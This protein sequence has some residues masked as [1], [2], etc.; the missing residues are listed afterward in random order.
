MESTDILV[1]LLSV[2]MSVV[3]LFT[4]IALFYA[5]KILKSLKSISE[6]AEHIADNVDAASTFFKNTAGPAAIAKMLANIV[7][8]MKNKK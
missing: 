6:K 2:G 3:L 7:E 5:I 4:T 8:T 1:I